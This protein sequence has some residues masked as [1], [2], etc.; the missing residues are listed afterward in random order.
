MDISTDSGV[1]FQ[2]LSLEDRIESTL[3]SFL[4]STEGR[5]YIRFCH[6]L[7]DIN[8][9]MKAVLANPLQPEVDDKNISN[10]IDYLCILAEYGV[11]N[12]AIAP[13]EALLMI[14]K[15]A[16]AYQA[17]PADTNEIWPNVS[18]A[19][20]RILKLTR[21]FIDTDD[22]LL[23]VEAIRQL[24]KILKASDAW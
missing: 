20:E 24:D 23:V 2:G 3:D 10:G 4:R 8:R 1:N 11:R 14:R 9:A 6:E 17:F 22:E 21:G 16:D 18:R 7:G 19:K 13:K 12:N 15:A 5:H